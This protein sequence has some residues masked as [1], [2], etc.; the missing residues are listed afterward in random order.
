[1]SLWCH[2]RYT[3]NQQLHV[4]S[5]HYALTFML[6]LR[7]VK[8]IRITSEDV[9]NHRKICNRNPAFRYWS[10]N[11]LN[12]SETL[13][14]RGWSQKVSV[15][16]HLFYCFS[17][18]TNALALS[19]TTLNDGYRKT[20]NLD[21]RNTKQ[22]NTADCRWHRHLN[23]VHPRTEDKPLTAKSDWSLSTICDI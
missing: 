12:T 14:L 18:H 4:G 2:T 16:C 17:S 8:T 6:M 13:C 11:F 19:I 20:K 7:H 15:F 23:Q 10:L 22:T 1:M 9:G 21:L 5:Q 3:V